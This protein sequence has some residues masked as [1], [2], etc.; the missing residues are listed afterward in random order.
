MDKTEKVKADG[1]KILE[2]T[3]D[4]QHEKIIHLNGLLSELINYVISADLS[5]EMNRKAA[6]ILAR[7]KEKL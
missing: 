2:E 1:I 5:P 7:Q 6:L 3:I 4:M